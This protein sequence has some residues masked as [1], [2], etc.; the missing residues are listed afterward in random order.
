[1]T[2]VYGC[3]NDMAKGAIKKVLT[4]GHRIHTATW[5]GTNISDKPEAE[6]IE[7]LHFF[8]SVPISTE[9][10]DLIREDVRPD[11]PWADDHFYERVSGVPLNPP[12]SSS[13]WGYAKQDNQD[14]KT[15][16]NIFDHTYPERFWPKYAGNSVIPLRGVRFAYGDLKDVISLLDRDPYTRQ[17]FLPIFFPEDTGA[18]NNIRVPC[19][20]GYHFIVRGEALHIT[21]WIRSLDVKRHLRND[22]YLAVRLLLYVLSQLRQNSPFWNTINPG[23][24]VFHSVSTHCFVGDQLSLKK[25]VYD[26]TR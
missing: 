14:F 12:P 13:S 9:D 24:L 10:L 1:M 3:L 2:T 15:E 5:Q 17:A 7:F 16:E 11:L 26:T 8:G 25:E 4:L 6:M 19:T 20:I 23:F 22:L 21:Y 18:I